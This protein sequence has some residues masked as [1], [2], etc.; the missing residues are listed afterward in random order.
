MRSQGVYRYNWRMR[1]F[2]TRSTPD[3]KV[4]SLMWPAGNT[5]INEPQAAWAQDLNLEDVVRGF[6]ADPRHVPFIRHTLTTLNT[7]PAIIGWR[8]AVLSDLLRN[9]ALVERIAL[10]V[11]RLADLRTEP[12]LLGR[13]QRPLLLD[14]AD[15]LAQLDLYLSVVQDL[16]VALN[17]SDLQSEGLRGLRQN[18]QT[19]INDENF[20]ALLIELPELQRPIQSFAGLTIGINLDSQLQPIAATLLSINDKPFTEARSFL[21]KLLGVSTSSEDEN[22]LAP[23]HYTPSDP[24]Q[25]P[26][27]P[28]FQDLERLI[29]Q[30]VQPVA[31]AL[32]RYVRLSSGPLVGLENELAFYVAVVGLI[33]RLEA[34]GITFCQPQ[35]APMDDRVSVIDGLIN[36]QL[37]LRDLA[38]VPISSDAAFDDRGR[39][40]ILT[41]PNSGGKTTYLQAVGLAHVLFQ[42]GL[43]IPARQARI[44]PVDLIFTHFPALESQQGRLSEE[45]ARLRHICLKATQYSLVLLNESLSSTMSSEAVY[46]AQ[47]VLGGLR[48][49]GVR[50]IFATHLVELAEHMGEIEA[51]AAGDSA[52][53]SLIAGV[54]MVDDSA[55]SDIRAVPTFQITRGLPQGRSYAREIAR[56]HG[57][58]LEQ[59]LDARQH[60]GRPPKA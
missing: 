38:H 55:A 5:P 18:L 24:D 45:A 40:A 32:R 37:A 41:G 43:F 3:V 10:L 52:L 2:R 26:F 20:Q 22:G 28:L 21:S 23:L 25:R 34:R 48:A 60:A 36:V 14:T 15:R 17:E 11:P 47:D 44:S 19:L 50:A 53:Y 35:I 6:N 58:S 9:P 30:T 29:S 51:S 57:I 13:R 7:D 39:I 54:Q 33:R 49:I 4:I 31:W 8:Q 42:A 1:K 59:I 56:R 12:A 16:H 27:S 46:V